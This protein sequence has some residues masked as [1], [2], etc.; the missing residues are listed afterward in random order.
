MFV[1]ALILLRANPVS[2]YRRQA[3][4]SSTFVGT[5]A[6]L[7][8]QSVV[9]S[10]GFLQ[11]LLSLFRKQMTQLLRCTPL[12]ISAFVLADASPDASLLDCWPQS[13]LNLGPD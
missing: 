10:I 13:S 9:R 1:L 12:V 8:E 6:K 2:I 11:N 4:T 7:R 5:D 3:Y